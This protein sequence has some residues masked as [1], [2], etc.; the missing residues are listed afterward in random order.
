MPVLATS[1]CFRTRYK[2][3][4]QMAINLAIYTILKSQTQELVPTP[5]PGGRHKKANIYFKPLNIR[6]DLNTLCIIKGKADSISK[7]LQ[8]TWPSVSRLSDGNKYTKSS[9]VLKY[10]RPTHIRQETPN[11]KVRNIMFKLWHNMNKFYPFFM[12]RYRYPPMSIISICLLAK[13]I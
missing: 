7:H 1:P 5:T 9:N 13:Y 11:A 4:I 6:H 8:D 3:Y 12:V 2:K 10:R